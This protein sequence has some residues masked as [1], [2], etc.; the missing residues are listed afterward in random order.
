MILARCSRKVGLMVV[1]TVHSSAISLAAQHPSAPVAENIIEQRLDQYKGNDSK[2]EAALRELFLE[3]G[4]KPANLSEQTVPTRKQP[5]VICVLPGT[6]SATIIV[7][8]HFDHADEGDGIVD[9]WSGASLLP[10]LFQALAVSP[11][12]HTFVFV[13]FTGEEN[14]LVGS[15]FYV[16]HLAPQELAN[17]EAMINL[18]SLGL[19]PTEV[20]ISQSDPRLVNTV[21]AM[22]QHLD[23]PITGMNVDGLGESDEE[24]FIAHKVC[25]LT[26]HSLTPANAAVLHRPADNPT[27]I[28]HAD[29]YETFR[30]IAA[31]LPALDDL[32]YPSGHTCTAKPV[33][34]LSYRGLRPLRR[35]S[36]PH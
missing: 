26:I 33:D 5:N 16:S 14:G 36:P 2:R 8:A 35:R 18:D 32:N 3:A 21:A 24:S 29:Y 7:G 11:R 1:L 9:N 25:T 22:A 12:R 10:S 19:G 13:G 20:W 30:L 15:D 28:H 23:S 27:A 4:C 17:I 6:T 34:N 31:Y